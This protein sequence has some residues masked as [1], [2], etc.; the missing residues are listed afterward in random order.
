M[1]KE[2]IMKK[3]VWID[4]ENW[5]VEPDKDEEG[6]KL[7]NWVSVVS[8]DDVK[9][10]IKKE[11]ERINK[12]IRGMIVWTTGASDEVKVNLKYYNQALEELTRKINEQKEN[13]KEK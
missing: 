6:N 1:N 4:E 11:R 7:P 12:I 8:T 13:I 10:L 9:S 5:Q 3:A 2:E